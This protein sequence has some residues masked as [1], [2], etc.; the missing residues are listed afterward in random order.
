VWSEFP[1]GD[2][3]EVAQ[4]GE[5]GQ[6]ERTDVTRRQLPEALRE[7]AADTVAGLRALGLKVELLSGDTQ[8]AVGE[9]AERL[10]ITDWKAAAGPEEKLARL[11]ALQEAG[12]RVAM[13]GDGINDVPVLAGADVSIAMNGATDLARTSADAVLLSPRLVRIVEAIQVSRATRRIIRQNLIWSVCYN[14]SALPLA[15]LGLVP[16]WVAALGMSASS[17]VVVG[18]ALRLAR[19]DSAITSKNPSP[20]PVPA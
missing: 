9:L 8:Q 12:I 5:G 16:P 17:L 13:V 15:A 2:L 18:N 4:A 1:G 3:Y 14:A 6:K 20:A 11:R 10:G 7:D 19:P